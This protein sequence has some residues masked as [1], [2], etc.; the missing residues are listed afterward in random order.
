M[1]TRRTKASVACL[2]LAVL[3]SCAPKLCLIDDVGG[4]ERCEARRQKLGR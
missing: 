2:L 3:A 4:Y 1:M